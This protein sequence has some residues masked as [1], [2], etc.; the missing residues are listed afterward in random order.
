MP[1]SDIM[2]TL[3]QK[4]LTVLQEDAHKIQKLIE[5]QMEN[6]S[7]RKCPLYEEVLDT[8]MFGLSKEVEFAIKIGLISDLVGKEILNRLQRDLDELYEALEKNNE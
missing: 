1:S 2:L 4:S 3:V 5:V 8:Q 7:T 6:L